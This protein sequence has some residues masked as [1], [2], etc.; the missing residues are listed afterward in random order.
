MT[1]PI[2]RHAQILSADAAALAGCADR[3]RDLAGRLR[4]RDT[5]PPWLDDLLTAHIAACGTA[6]A[7][8]ATAADRIWD[9][10]G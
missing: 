3:L 9:L 5:V 10:T 4:G 6:A 7:D 2:E 1:A 8:V